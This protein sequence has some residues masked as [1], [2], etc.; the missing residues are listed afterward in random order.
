MVISSRQIRM[1][2]NFAKQTQ[3]IYV[4][5]VLF[6]SQIYTQFL[7]Q[8]EMTFAYF[9][10]SMNRFLLKYVKCFAWILSKFNQKEK[11]KLAKKKFTS[12]LVRQRNQHR[13]P[14]HQLHR[15]YRKQPNAGYRPSSQARASCMSRPCQWQS[16]G[17]H[18]AKSNVLS[19]WQGESVRKFSIITIWLLCF[20][21]WK[22]YLRKAMKSRLWLN[23]VKQ[24]TSGRSCGL[25]DRINL[26]QSNNLLMLVKMRRPL[27]I[28]WHPCCPSSKLAVMVPTLQCPYLRM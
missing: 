17:Q 4:S 14:H 23:Q 7:D 6:Q 3:M 9:S 5:F 26:C 22:F 27:P 19:M 10:T 21:N 15:R 1:S 18:L 12:R 13:M 24:L 2:R 25:M 8:L 28:G 16:R 11:Y 20:E